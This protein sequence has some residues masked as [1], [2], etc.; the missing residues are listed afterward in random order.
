MADLPAEQQE[1]KGIHQGL[2][3]CDRSTPRCE[4]PIYLRAV[5]EKG[6]QHRKAY[7]SGSRHS[8]ATAVRLTDRGL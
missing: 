3:P 1:E 2:H 8:P 7:S 4:G 6:I 5:E